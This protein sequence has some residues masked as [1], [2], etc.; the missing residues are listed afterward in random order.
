MVLSPLFFPGNVSL[1]HLLLPI[2]IISFSLFVS[3]LLL[4]LSF[5]RLL[6]LR[7]PHT[8]KIQKKTKNCPHEYKYTFIALLPVGVSL[9]S[10][11]GAAALCYTSNATVCFSPTAITFTAATMVRRLATFCHGCSIHTVV[12]QSEILLHSSHH[13]IGLPSAMF[14]KL[15]AAIKVGRGDVIQFNSLE[16]TVHV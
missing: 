16:S 13:M 1:L 3:S 12:L 2:F 5:C 11:G 14:A 8:Y 9:P 6:V 7:P 15:I 4:F 10:V